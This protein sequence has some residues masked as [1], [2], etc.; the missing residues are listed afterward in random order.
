M[1]I[2]FQQAETKPKGFSHILVALAVFTGLVLI[3]NINRHTELHLSIPSSIGQGFYT[4]SSSM[5]VVIPAPLP[6][7]E[8]VQVTAAPALLT[9]PAP[10]P[11]AV[12]APTPDVP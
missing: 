7:Q 9:T 1:N 4:E 10:L 12:L 8:Q 5:P 11:Q 2:H 6:P 3:L